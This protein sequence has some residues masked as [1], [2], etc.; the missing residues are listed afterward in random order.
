MLQKLSLSVSLPVFWGL[1]VFLV[2]QLSPLFGAGRVPLIVYAAHFLAAPVLFFLCGFFFATIMRHALLF[3]VTAAGC[4]GLYMLAVLAGQYGFQLALW[5][6]DAV[7][8]AMP[9]VVLTFAAQAGL[10]R[11]YPPASGGTA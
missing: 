1:S 6:F 7:L 4:Y 5:R 3:A 9:V 8:G 11:F 2:G 10:M